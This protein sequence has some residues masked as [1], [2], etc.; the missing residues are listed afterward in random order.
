VSGCAH[1]DIINTI[2]YAQQLTG[3]K[4]VY[5][6]LGGFRLAGKE[7]EPNI[8]QTVKELNKIPKTGS[9]FT[10]YRLARNIRNS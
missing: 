7:N 3:I 6:V 5:V 10:L 2:L 4:T 1:A 8:S 9:A